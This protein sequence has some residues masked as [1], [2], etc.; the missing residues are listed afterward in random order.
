MVGDG[1]GGQHAEGSSDLV[2]V[3]LVHGHHR[4]VQTQHASLNGFSISI[5]LLCINVLHK[6]TFNVENLD[7]LR[8]R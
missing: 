7:S 8:I 5:H 4:Q 6:F 3:C 2:Q 1:G